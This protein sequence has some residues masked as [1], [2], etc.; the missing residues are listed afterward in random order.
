MPKSSTTISLPCIYSQSHLTCLNI[1]F[2]FARLQY[3]HCPVSI[4]LVSGPQQMPFSGSTNRCLRLLF[5]SSGH[6]NLLPSLIYHPSSPQSL[7]SHISLLYP[8]RIPRGFIHDTQ[9]SPYSEQAPYLSLYGLHFFFWY[10]PRDKILNDCV[11]CSSLELSD[12]LKIIQNVKMFP[13]SDVE[14]FNFWNRTV[15]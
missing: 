14:L 4:H 10:F 9:I 7:L 1:T 11:C 3:L 2:P 5:L 8:I 12:C 6:L 13:C 15:H